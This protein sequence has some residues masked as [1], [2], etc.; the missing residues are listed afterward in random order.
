MRRAV[1]V[2]AVLALA[3]CGGGGHARTASRTAR[4]SSGTASPTIRPRTSP[5]QRS[6]RAAPRRENEGTVPSFSLAPEEVEHPEHALAD[7]AGVGAQAHAL[8]GVVAGEAPAADGLCGDG[9]RVGDDE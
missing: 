2:L 9:V 6:R 1:V 3:G 7:V 4:S 8:G 5:T